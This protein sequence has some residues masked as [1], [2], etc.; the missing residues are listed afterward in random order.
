[1]LG[2]IKVWW[3]CDVRWGDVWALFIV[4]AAFADC[5]S[6]LILQHCRG[7][8]HC[9]HPGPEY[10]RD[11]PVV[12]HFLQ[13]SACQHPDPVTRI[14]CVCDNSVSSSQLSPHLC[15]KYWDPASTTGAILISPICIGKVKTIFSPS[16]SNLFSI[17][18]IF[19][20]ILTAFIASCIYL[21]EISKSSHF[22]FD[23]PPNISFPWLCY[24]HSP[25]LSLAWKYN[26]VIKI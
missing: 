4:T 18:C 15:Y 19:N 5:Y 11:Q 2:P 8:H 22:R 16:F 10:C 23:C 1:M 20:T 24:S 21:R 3:G 14:F 25:G 26:S 17:I 6:Q 7:V 12:S 9:S 13:T